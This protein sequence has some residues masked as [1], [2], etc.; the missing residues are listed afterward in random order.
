MDLIFADDARQSRPSRIGIGPLVAIGG[1]HVRAEAVGALEREIESLCARTGFPPGEQFKWSPTKKELVMRALVG[2]SRLRFYQDLFALAAA[3]RVKACVVLEDTTKSAARTG[4]VKDGRFEPGSKTHEEDAI[5]LFLERCQ[6]A[7]RAA[8]R[9][10]LVMATKPSGGNTS[11][12]KFLGQ[13]FELHQTGTE[14]TPLDRMPLGVVT[15][16]S[17]EKRLLQLA[18]VVTSCTTARVSGES[19]FSPAVFAMI[20][21][22]LRRGLGHVGGVG[23]KIHPDGR[24]LNLYHWL[25]GDPYYTRR[26]RVLELPDAGHLYYQ[27]AGEAA[28]GLAGGGFV[29]AGK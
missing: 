23:L 4:Q 11:E 5:A 12:G 10:G 20:Q 24:Y 27:D 26:G 6:N 16:P 2:D 21:P 9:E 13:C 25:V 1:V 29:P 18:D 8:G 15:A 22:L 17:R 7:L 14:Y 28:H 19:D 3:H